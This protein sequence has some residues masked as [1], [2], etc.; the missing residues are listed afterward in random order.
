[1]SCGVGHRHSLDWASLWCR[2]EAVALITALVWEPPYAT[3]AALKKKKKSHVPN[4]V[5]FPPQSL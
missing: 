3:G 1:M 2:P 4:G 5:I